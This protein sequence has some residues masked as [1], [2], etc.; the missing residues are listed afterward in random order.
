MMR[1]FVT[2]LE[3]LI[4]PHTDEAFVRGIINGFKLGLEISEIGA[5]G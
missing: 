5:A 4:P 2:D 1:D 3:E